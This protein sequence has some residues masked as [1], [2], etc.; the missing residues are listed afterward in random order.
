MSPRT[1]LDILENRKISFPCQNSNLGLF[2]SWPSLHND[3][4]IPDHTLL[5]EFVICPIQERYLCIIFMDSHLNY[6]GP[7]M[8]TLTYGS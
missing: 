8:F 3:E 7:N 1:G 5:P 2:S 6:S 4:T